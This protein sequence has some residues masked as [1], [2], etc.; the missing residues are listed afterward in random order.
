MRLCKKKYNIIKKNSIWGE[1]F[2]NT[3]KHND[4]FN[5]MQ[6]DIAVDIF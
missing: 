1:H 3:D 2:V 4:I 5:E 6:A